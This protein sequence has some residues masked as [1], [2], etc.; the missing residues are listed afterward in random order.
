MKVVQLCRIFHAQASPDLGIIADS[1][2]CGSVLLLLALLF[3]SAT[4]AVLATWLMR[5]QKST[6]E[7]RSQHRYFLESTRSSNL[8][9]FIDQMFQLFYI[10]DTSTYSRCPRTGLRS[11]F[12]RVIEEVRAG[13]GARIRDSLLG[14]QVVARSPCASC[15]IALGERSYIFTVIHAHLGQMVACMLRQM[16]MD[17]MHW[18][19]Y[20]RQLLERHERQ[21]VNHPGTKR[22]PSLSCSVAA[23]GNPSHPTAWRIALKNICLCFC[24]GHGLLLF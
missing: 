10:I 12:K 19:E 5:S 18:K 24:N 22:C 7:P 20:T 23:F 8:P 1:Q 2:A 14:R 4:R 6:H 9:E 21:M 15:E 17:H 3:R 11:A 16:V 13:D